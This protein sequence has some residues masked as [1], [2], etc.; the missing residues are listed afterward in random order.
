MVLENYVKIEE[1][2][3]KR[4]RMKNPR[5]IEKVI[6]DPKTKMLKHVRALELDVYEE[7]GRPVQK[8]FSTLSEKLATIL[9][10]LHQQG[11]LED[12]LIEIHKIG[13]DYAVEWEV[14]VLD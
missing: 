1:C 12:H 8:I 6:R 14:R 13:R 2:K 11:L 7:D 10:S 5:I 3:P 4:L 9:W